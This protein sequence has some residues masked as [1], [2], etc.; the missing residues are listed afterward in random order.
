ML[1]GM[2]KSSE[3]YWTK[4][5]EVVEITEEEHRGPYIFVEEPERTTKK[6]VRAKKSDK[7]EKPVKVEP[8][9][10][11]TKRKPKMASL[12]NFFNEPKSKKK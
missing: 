11:T 8:V 6:K 4:S 12:E 1:E 2:K 7:S 10:T 3:S 5:I 9:K